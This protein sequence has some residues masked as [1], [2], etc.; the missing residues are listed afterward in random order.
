MK[1]MNKPICTVEIVQTPDRILVQP[2]WKNVNR[3][4]STAYS[5]GVDR[6]LAE[7]LASFIRSGKAWI[8]E[9]QVMTDV[10]GQTYVHA[11]LRINTRRM[12][13]ELK[14]HGF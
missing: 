14:R 1:H 2:V 12:N 5:T 6:K 3:P 13:A 10:N 9:P 8:K 7:R 11:G 4:R